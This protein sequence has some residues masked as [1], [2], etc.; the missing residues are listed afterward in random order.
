MSK[1]LPKGRLKKNTFLS[2][3]LAGELEQVALEYEMKSKKKSHAT[4]LILI[5]IFKREMKKRNL[6]FW[7][8]MKTFQNFHLTKIR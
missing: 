6:E 5:S 2:L 8:V 7:E 1:N 3:K 4:G